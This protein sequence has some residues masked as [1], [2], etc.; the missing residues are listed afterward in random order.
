[1][2][3]IAED[4]LKL[5]ARLS[6]E[7]TDILVPPP[8]A[9]RPDW[10]EPQMVPKSI[11]IPLGHTAD[12]PVPAKIRIR[13]T[14][15][16]YCDTDR[17][18]TV[19]TVDFNYYVK[20]VLPNEWIN[21]WPAESLR[22]G[23]MAAK[24]YAWYWVGLGGKW[25]DADVYDS[26]CD[27][28]YN[29][30]YSYAST[31]EAVDYT[32]NWLI[33][34]DGYLIQAFYRAYYS[35]CEDAGL[36]GSCMGQWDSKDLAED[37]YTWDQ[38]LYYFYLETQLSTWSGAAQGYSLRYYGNG[39]DDIDRV[40]ILVDD[41]NNS[42]PG[43]PAD[44]G[45]QD[46]TLEW[47]LKALSGENPAPSVSCGENIN[48][49]YGNIILDRDRFDQDRKFG[50]SLGGGK[51]A[52]GVSGEWWLPGADNLTICGVT[53]VTDGGWHHVAVQRRRSDGWLWLYVDGQLEAQADGPDGDV[54]YPDNGVPGSH[55]GESRQEP[56]TDSDPYLVLAAEKHDA[57]PPGLYPSF[58]GWIDELRLSNSLR[59][60]G[61][62]TP[63]SRPFESDGN[64]VALYHFD[65]GG[66]VT[67]DESGAAGGP[68][69]GIREYGG[70]PAGPIWS[71]ETPFVPCLVGFLPCY[72][73]ILPIVQDSQ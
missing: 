41:S 56:C 61:N 36:A 15:Y 11:A 30:N 6:A 50:V 51:V 20:H 14:G 40:K 13:V 64:T 69:N 57:P 63:R 60:L 37:G 1:M 26:T 43:P 39:I 65:A 8:R 29:P 12:Q 7:A 24:M 58:S 44:V 28:V 52:F 5:E 47:W 72:E 55:C 68:S 22:A 17:P 35:Q 31:D 48:W 34:E 23:A 9:E 16:A 67:L 54:S 70:E 53:D 73:L 3:L 2:R 59:Y 10:I 19:E 71:S 42:D 46:F 27:Q 32:W 45:A 38:I 18:Y 21:S 33:E 25:P 49:I 66:N 62:F 4:T